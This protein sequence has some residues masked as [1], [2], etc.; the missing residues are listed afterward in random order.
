MSVDR[1]VVSTGLLVLL[2]GAGLVAVARFEGRAWWLLRVAW[3]AALVGAV[4]GLLLHG[5]FTAGLPLSRTLV[6]TLLAQTIG[7]R[8]GG[9][10]PCAFCCCSSWLPSCEPGR[11]GRLPGCAP[12]PG[13][14]SGAGG[15]AGGHPGA[16]R[17]CR[18]GIR[19]RRRGCRR[20]RRALLGG[21]CLVRRRCP[22]GDLRAA[23]PGCELAAGGTPLFLSGVH[24]HGGH[25]SDWVGAELAA[26]AEPADPG[27]DRL[28]SLAAGQDGG[29]PATDRGRRPQ[30][31]AGPAPA[32]G[33]SLGR[34]CSST[35]T[36]EGCCG[37]RPE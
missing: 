1:L 11:S 4:A 26:G 27:A 35:P 13:W 5:P 9:I 8:F 22:A 33:T 37:F 36:G 14:R 23:A 30:P 20:R 34:R 19:R 3:W 7:T 18:W 31:G 25:R 15:G 6:A 32:D 28:W 29:A 24:G 10:W 21:R 17:A 12:A 16:E 2:G